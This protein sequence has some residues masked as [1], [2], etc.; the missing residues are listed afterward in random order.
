M[1]LLD[2][3]MQAIKR[4]LGSAVTLVAAESGESVVIRA[5]FDAVHKSV[6]IEG[7]TE[8]ASQQPCVDV[9]IADVG[10]IPTIGDY[11]FCAS[12][13]YGVNNVEND[14]R[15]S[16]RLS[17]VTSAGPGGNFGG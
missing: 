7:G 13:W 5:P 12:Q 3:P 11:V 16:V 2:L 1:A 8:I 17:L 9:R 6:R 14:G 10:W 15:G 4:V